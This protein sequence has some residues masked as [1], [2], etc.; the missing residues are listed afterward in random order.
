[1]ATSLRTLDD[2]L[3]PAA[4]LAQALVAML[5]AGSRTRAL[6]L[7]GT[8]LF[9]E[10]LVDP[11][12]WHTL[13]QFERLLQNFHGLR[14]QAETAFQWG[15]QLYRAA[16]VPRS[17]PELLETGTG[18]FPL[19][20]ADLQLHDDGRVSLHLNASTHR[21]LPRQLIE[22]ALVLYRMALDDLA[23]ATG[24]EL[25]PLEYLLPYAEPDH[26]EQYLVHLPG[27]RVFDAPFAA[28]RFGARQRPSRLWGMAL[29][30]PGWRSPAVDLRDPDGTPVQLLLPA[31]RRLIRQQSVATSLDGAARW[32]AVSTATLKRR[33]AEHGVRYQ[34]LL[35]QTRCEQAA[36]ALLFADLPLEELSRRLH[37]GTDPSNFRRAF[38]RWTGL[39]PRMLKERLADA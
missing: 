25:A 31:L 12:R 36:S 23:V 9:E 33:L 11:Q 15:A 10:D 39:T 37:F 8:A 5:P 26:L 38:K 21:R 14:P 24:T 7:R 20:T 34:E 1:M 16:P 30:E 3:L 29:D 19:V 32:S 4:G 13:R 28:I 27:R 18:R 17:L 22:A 2:P 6:V 35:D